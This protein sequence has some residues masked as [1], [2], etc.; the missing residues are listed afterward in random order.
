MCRKWSSTGNDCLRGLAGVH[1]DPQISFFGVQTLKIRV[2]FSSKYAPFVLAFSPRYSVCA[3]AQSCR[4]VLEWALPSAVDYC[5][6]DNV[7]LKKTCSR[8]ALGCL[9]CFR[10]CSACFP[11]FC[12]MY[13]RVSHPCARRTHIPSVPIHRDDTKWK[14]V[15][16]KFQYLW[17]G[18]P[19]KA[20]QSNAPQATFFYETKCAAGKITCRCGV[21]TSD[22]KSRLAAK[23]VEI[24]QHAVAFCLQV[25]K[26]CT[27]LD[28]TLLY[29]LIL[30][31]FGKFARKNKNVSAQRLLSADVLERWLLVCCFKI[32]FTLLLTNCF[33]STT[34][35]SMKC[36]LNWIT[37]RIRVRSRN[38]TQSY[39]KHGVGSF[40]NEPEFSVESS[41]QGISSNLLL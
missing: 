12:C 26:K 23:F 37:L 40:S 17:I 31:I 7:K 2:F 1:W 39:L 38:D 14:C 41:L 20:L 24:F 13:V 28:P 32:T 8:I 15:L 5:E 11:L 34:A 4:Q 10:I 22:S 33:V 25:Q 3:R 35:N 18:N 30:R 27:D 6:N 9:I 36:L 29:I 19:N 16:F 21:A